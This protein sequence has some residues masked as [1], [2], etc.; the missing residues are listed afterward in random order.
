MD[1]AVISKV[2]QKKDGIK[3]KTKTE[4]IKRKRKRKRQKK[5]E[6]GGKQPFCNG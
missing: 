2:L 3:N 6:R 5:L 1:C 4:N